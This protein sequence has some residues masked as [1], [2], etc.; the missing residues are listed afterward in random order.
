MS[1]LSS[2]ADAMEPDSK[3]HRT[4]QPEMQQSAPPAD[5][6][7]SSSSLPST[8][9]SPHPLSA[10]DGVTAACLLSFLSWHEQVPLLYA[11]TGLRSL[12]QSPSLCQSLL[13][14]RLCWL[15]HHAERMAAR[16]WDAAQLLKLLLL[17]LGRVELRML[18]GHSA[19][20]LLAQLW[21]EATLTSIA[22]TSSILFNPHYTPPLPGR[23]PGELD[24]CKYFLE[25]DAPHGVVLHTPLDSLD[26]AERRKERSAEE[27]QGWSWR[28]G[29]PRRINLWC[30]N[31]YQMDSI[32]S[33]YPDM[34]PGVDVDAARTVL[35]TIDLRVCWLAARYGDANSECLGYYVGRSEKNEEGELV[36][37]ST[38]DE[39]RQ[40][41]R[42]LAAEDWSRLPVVVHSFF[43]ARCLLFPDV[44]SAMT[45]WTN[46]LAEWWRQAQK[47]AGKAGGK[48]G[49]EGQAERN[50]TRA[51]G[52]RLR[53][54][55]LEPLMEE[56]DMD[57]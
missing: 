6:S 56:A 11:S 54:V 46:G 41:R 48:A 8:P 31:P 35:S 12:L 19:P 5:S 36:E 22:T 23:D 43:A 2:D 17:R 50:P 49:G 30:N 3:R 27:A 26:E 21:L 53:F 10:L 44:Q 38:D 40:R 33:G 1:Q 52:V 42:G 47:E 32:I 7:S 16:G 29:Q 24:W 14:S 39:C 28:W 20:S 45:V 34:A 18:Y 51:D 4:E 57:L 37:V 15:P 55:D 13:R 9:S 25:V